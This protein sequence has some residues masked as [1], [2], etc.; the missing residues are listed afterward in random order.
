MA[1]FAGI[2]GEMLNDLIRKKKDLAKRRFD[3]PLANEIVAKTFFLPLLLSRIT[4]VLPRTPTN[5]SQSLSNPKD[6]I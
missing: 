1:L 4:Q 6:S 5:K 2:W 3:V